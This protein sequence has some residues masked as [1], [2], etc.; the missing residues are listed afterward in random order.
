MK[1]EKGIPIPKGNGPQPGRK[2][3]HHYPLGKMNI[4]DSF[5]CHDDLKT[6]SNRTQVHRRRY[7]TLFQIRKEGDGYRVW[8]VAPPSTTPELLS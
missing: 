7:G 4:G 6:I 2:P 5:L 8:R 1:I 3:S